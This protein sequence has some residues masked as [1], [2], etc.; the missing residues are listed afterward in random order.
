MISGI[1]SISR[2][3]MPMRIVTV[4]LGHDPHAPMSLSRTTS[5]SIY[6]WWVWKFVGV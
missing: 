5:P 4:L 1:F 6:G 2:R 3:S